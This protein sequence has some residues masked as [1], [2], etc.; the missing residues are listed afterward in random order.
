MKEDS[1]L[2]HPGTPETRTLLSHLRGFGLDD[3]IELSFVLQI[4]K[5]IYENDSF[6]K[7]HHGLNGLFF[8]FSTK[9]GLNTHNFLSADEL[10]FHGLVVMLIQH[11]SHE[12]TTENNDTFFITTRY[13]SKPMTL[14]RE[15]ISVLFESKGEVKRHS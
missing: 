14:K 11:N 2:I 10:T 7:D 8:Q 12:K 15:Y 5:L 3:Y 13:F 9:P 6:E 1:V 4:N